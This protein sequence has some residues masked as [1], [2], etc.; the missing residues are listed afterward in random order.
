MA[1]IESPKAAIGQAQLTQYL[2]I[3]FSLVFVM[4]LIMGVSIGVLPDFV[5][6]ELKLSNVWVGVVIGMQYIATLCTRQFSG[7]MADHKGGKITLIVG[8]GL[9]MISGVLLLGAVNFNILSLRLVFLL[10]GRILLGAGES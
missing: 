2:A 8:I 6:N 4:Y 7:S 5:H 9:C 10:L 1:S 3:V